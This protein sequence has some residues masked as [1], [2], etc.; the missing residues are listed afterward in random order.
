MSPESVPWGRTVTLLADYGKEMGEIYGFKWVIGTPEVSI[1]AWI[2]TNTFA[3]NLSPRRGRGKGWLEVWMWFQGRGEWF[4][5]CAFSP[6]SSYLHT[7][8]W[9]CLNQQKWPHGSGACIY[10]TTCTITR[11]TL[12]SYP[13]KNALIWALVIRLPS[14][15][16]VPFLGL[17]MS[18][19]TNP[20]SPG[21]SQKLTFLSCL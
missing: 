7:C 20:T 13:E 14:N 6:L 8:P 12:Q 5:T 16:S 11:G 15:F 2:F 9:Y 17:K 4:S 18:R 19:F 1:S 3:S 10:C 21:R